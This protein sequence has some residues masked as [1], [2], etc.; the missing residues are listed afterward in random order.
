[1]QI[2]RQDSR[3][4]LRSVKKPLGR[5]LFITKALN[6][7]SLDVRS[8]TKPL[9]GVGS[10][11]DEGS[12]IIGSVEENEEQRT[13]GEHMYTTTAFTAK[14]TNYV[15]L[16]INLGESSDSSEEVSSNESEEGT[17]TFVLMGTN[18]RV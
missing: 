4:W 17:E 18:V 2:P 16:G 7:Q 12:S 9:A 11:D 5:N 8:A 13:D 6:S 14:L 10:E 3:A 15:F 1:M